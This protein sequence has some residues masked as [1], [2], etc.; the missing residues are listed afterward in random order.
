MIDKFNLAFVAIQLRIFFKGIRV[1]NLQ[2]ISPESAILR[3]QKLKSKFSYKIS[4]MARLR[5]TRNSTRVSNRVYH[6]SRLCLF[7]SK[8][9]KACQMG[10]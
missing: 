10:T 6:L 5:L 3:I 1:F 7:N 8:S 4:H 2:P 9:S